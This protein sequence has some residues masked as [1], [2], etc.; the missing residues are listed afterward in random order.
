MLK[1]QHNPRAIADNRLVANKTAMTGAMAKVQAL[2]GYNFERALA[3]GDKP[4]VAEVGLIA[5]DVLAQLPAAITYEGPQR[6]K[7]YSQAALI[8]LL[9]EAIKELKAQVDAIPTTPP[10]TARASTAKVVPPAPTA[11]VVEDVPL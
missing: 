7:H 4:S 2:V 10:V 11:P 1:E 3:M 8:A 9:V 5:D 6:I